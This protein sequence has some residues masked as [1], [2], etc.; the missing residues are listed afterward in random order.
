[1][2]TIKRSL[3]VFAT[4]SLLFI[5]CKKEKLDEAQQTVTNA[6]LISTNTTQYFIADLEGV[7]GIEKI[8]FQDNDYKFLSSYCHISQVYALNV[9]TQ[10]NDLVF[11][12]IDIDADI[13][14]GELGSFNVAFLLYIHLSVGESLPGGEVLIEELETINGE[15]YIKGTFNAENIS[16]GI[17]RLRI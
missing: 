5:S 13:K 10:S 11:K 9:L 6:D 16:N 8:N 17:F 3:F 1:M 15:N 7:E 2:K 12:L 14:N 4:M